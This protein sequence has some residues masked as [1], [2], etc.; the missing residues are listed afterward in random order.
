M[1]DEAVTGV[2][3]RPRCQCDCGKRWVMFNLFGVLAAPQRAEVGDD[4]E[5]HRRVVA[6]RTD[7]LAL[8]ERLQDKLD[9]TFVVV[10]AA[11]DA[12]RDTCVL[13]THDA[14]VQTLF[15]RS[16]H[17]DD[18]GQDI[19]EAFAAEGVPHGAVYVDV[20]EDV[21]KT[22]EAAGFRTVW[23]HPACDLEAELTAL[24]KLDGA[25]T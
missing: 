8:L 13:L 16:Y 1:K 19:F 15:R 6:W 23:A 24:L 3:T 18:Y 5:L 2:S 10:A 4:D 14:R 7:R 9:A 25:S 12:S 17:V 11:A 20:R 22:A 21:C